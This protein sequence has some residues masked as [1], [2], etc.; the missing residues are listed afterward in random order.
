MPTSPAT[1]HIGLAARSIGALGLALAA[2]GCAPT[3]QRPAQEYLAQG[4]RERAC[5]RGYQVDRELESLSD[6]ASSAADP[7]RRE[8]LLQ[9]VDAVFRAEQQAADPSVAI[10]VFEEEELRKLFGSTLGPFAERLLLVHLRYAASRGSDLRLQA[11]LHVPGES[12]VATSTGKDRDALARLFQNEDFVLLRQAYVETGRTP[13]EWNVY[14]GVFL[15]LLID[16]PTVGMVPVGRN[17]AEARQRPASGVI[18]SRS[19]RKLE[20]YKPMVDRVSR[21]LAERC[22][23]A[24]QCERYEIFEHLWKPGIS[25]D[26][27]EWRAPVPTPL[28]ELRLQLGSAVGATRCKVKG[29]VFVPLP[30]G[31]SMAQRVNALFPGQPRPIR[32]LP[33]APP[34]GRMVR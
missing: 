30:P 4:D 7:F 9:E 15:Y 1:R 29:Q 32:E 12:W 17:I 19:E 27:T 14:L 25:Y 20:Q 21:L 22:D 10:H 3:L 34:Q 33:A 8:H 28:L 23:G 13:P 18:V 16:L 6:K 11:N 24:G 5:L 2:L 31:E 26:D